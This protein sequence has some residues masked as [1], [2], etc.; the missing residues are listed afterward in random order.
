[1]H[2]TD[3]VNGQRSAR[4]VA[5]AHTVLPVLRVNPFHSQEVGDEYVL[6][7]FIACGYARAAAYEINAF[8][9][10]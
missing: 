8:R 5:S 9:C 4:R 2:C 10:I 6:L 1:M 3:M 7:L